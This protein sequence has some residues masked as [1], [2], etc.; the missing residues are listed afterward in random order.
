MQGKQQQTTTTSITEQLKKITVHK[1]DGET[2]AAKKKKEAAPP[3]AKA[4][5]VSTGSDMAATQEEIKLP[6][7]FMVK[8]IG[9]REA[10]GLWGIKNTRK[11]VDEMVAAAK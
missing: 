3:P 6:Q 9:K 7:T 2:K 1:S 4:Q 8:Y 10:R 5:Q 11:P